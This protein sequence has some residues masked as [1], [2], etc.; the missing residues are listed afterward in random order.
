MHPYHAIYLVAHD[1][2]PNIFAQAAKMVSAK[3]FPRGAHFE[4]QKICW[5]HTMGIQYST[6]QCLSTLSPPKGCM[7]EN[8]MLSVFQHA[9]YAY[10]RPPYVFGAMYAP[11]FV[12]T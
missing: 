5:A 12:I 4:A 3:G 11:I 10:I 7:L 2:M 1:P 8:I 6:T 9:Y